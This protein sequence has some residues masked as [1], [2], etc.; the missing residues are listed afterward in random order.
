[1]AMAAEGVVIVGGG[2][3]GLA[4]AIE[5]RRRMGIPVTVIERE[6]EA[7]GIP[8]H[9]S[10]TGFGVRDLRR[11][12][13]GPAYARRYR[14]LAEAVGVELLAETMVTGWEGESLSLTGPGGLRAIQPPAV[15]LATGCR[16]RPRAARLVPG[17]RPT[18]VMTTSTL[19]QLIHLRGRRVGR[20]AIVVGAEHVSFSAVATLA[21]GGA[22]V[23]GLVT[24]LPRHQSLAAFRVGAAI[25]YRA[26]VWP[27][28]ALSAIHG[29]ERVEEVELTDLDGGQTRT[30]P[31]DLVVFTG[32][33]IP[34]HELAVMAGCELDPATLGPRVDP[35]LRTS[36]RG[37]FAIGNLLHPAE[38]ADICAL[39]GRH[40][41]RGAAD[42]LAPGA[43]EWP[44]A[45]RLVARPP[46]L[47]IAPNLLPRDSHRPP[48]DHFLLRSSSFL[49]LPRLEVHQDSRVL[50][51]GRLARLVPNR[52]A[53][54]P[55]GW[56]S[57]V[58]PEDGPVTIRVK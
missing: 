36:V 52:S 6:A 55:A 29:A 50:W 43:G 25:R 31:C 19:Q 20:R 41:A 37:V 16:E 35:A 28:T 53:Q 4:A 34:D 38:T 24:E 56:A 27:R 15:I 8:R 11:V 3:S 49:R 12:L 22:S 18:G 47:W 7:G 23:A 39:D 45:V 13:S 26:P 9:S 58:D 44:S 54:I 1:M 42:Y 33:W 48:R 17:S 40:V 21:Q 2:P 14:D 51:R 57:G 5:L 30:V 32:D 46:L 10:H